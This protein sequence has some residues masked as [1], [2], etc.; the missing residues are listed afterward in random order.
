MGVVA[1]RLADVAIEA[2]FGMVERRDE[3]ISGC[4]RSKGL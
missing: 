3:A 2:I 4:V 1:F